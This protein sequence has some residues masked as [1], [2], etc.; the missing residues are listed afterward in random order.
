MFQRLKKKF[1]AFTF[2]EVT[3]LQQL[4]IHVIRQGR[5]K[6]PSFNS[7]ERYQHIL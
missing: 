2:Q 6:Q 3:A 7:T 1:P 5:S 4:E